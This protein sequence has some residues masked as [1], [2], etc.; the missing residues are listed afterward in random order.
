MT[1]SEARAVSS[2][3]R[4]RQFRA[5]VPPHGVSLALCLGVFLKILRKSRRHIPRSVC[6]CALSR[7][8][9][10]R[11][12]YRVV[13]AA[14][15]ASVDFQ[16][17]TKGHIS[18]PVSLQVLENEGSAEGAHGLRKVALHSECYLRPSRPGC[19]DQSSKTS[20]SEIPEAQSLASAFAATTMQRLAKP[21][22]MTRPHPARRGSLRSGDLCASGLTAAKH[23]KRPCSCGRPSSQ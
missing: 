10:T 3:N 12:K 13:H 4:L 21:Q 14:F 1:G 5:A 20:L 17:G 8:V 11:I 18:Q 16:F 9:E 22:D 7:S 2:C 23:T 6:K 19:A 15:R